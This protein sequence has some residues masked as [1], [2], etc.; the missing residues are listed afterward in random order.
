LALALTASISEFSAEAGIR[1]LDALFL[2]EGFSTLD[3]ETLNVAID[4]LQALQEGD[5]MIGVISHVADLA[6]RLPSRINVVKNVSGSVVVRESGYMRER[7][8]VFI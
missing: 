6:E 1:K 7:T 4:A 2:D 8:G 3:A 5:R